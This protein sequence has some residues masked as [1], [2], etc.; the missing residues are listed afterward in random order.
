MISTLLKLGFWGSLTL[1]FIPIDLG[2]GEQNKTV[3]AF[4]AVIAAKATMDDFREICVRKPEVCET[5]SAAITTIS[6][7][8]RAGAKMML[9]Y[10]ES[11]PAQNKAPLPAKEIKS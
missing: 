3:S 5:G 9:E 10:V 11:E 1:L 2:A 7:R 8:A 6:S 4:E